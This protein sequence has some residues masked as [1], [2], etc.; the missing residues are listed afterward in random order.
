MSSLGVKTSFYGPL[1]YKIFGNKNSPFYGPTQSRHFVGVKTS[2]CRCTAVILWVFWV[3]YVFQVF[4]F[5]DL[6]GLVGLSCISGLL[7]LLGLRHHFKKQTGTGT[8]TGT[9]RQAPAPAPAPK[10][11]N[12]HRHFV[13]CKR[14]KRRKRPKRHKKPKRSTCLFEWCRCR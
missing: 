9:M 14:P 10:S 1:G 3:F 13:V 11:S 4:G 7:S 12:R 8:G 6:L 5:F 2:F